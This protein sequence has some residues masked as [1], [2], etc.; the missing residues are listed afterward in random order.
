MTISATPLSRLG[1][2]REE[3]LIL[4]PENQRT[5][6]SRPSPQGSEADQ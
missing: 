1:N 6:S 4:W 3:V 2:D 5:A